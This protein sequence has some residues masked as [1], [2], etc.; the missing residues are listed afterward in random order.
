VAVQ[1]TLPAGPAVHLACLG[2]TSQLSQLMAEV[3]ADQAQVQLLAM[4][5]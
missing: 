5:A 2:L 4:L 1:V 3:V